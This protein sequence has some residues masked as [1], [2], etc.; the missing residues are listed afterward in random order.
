[1]SRAFKYL[2]TFAAGA[3]ASWWACQNS[4][5]IGKIGICQKSGGCSMGGSSVGGCS[6]G[7]SC[8]CGKGGN[9]QC[10]KGFRG[11]PEKPCRAICLLKPDGG[12]NVNGKVE[13]T[14]DGKV[15]AI[16]AEI[17]GLPPNTK[18]GFHIHQFGDLSEGCKTAGAHYN[19]F[20][21]N[22]GYF[23]YKL[24]ILLGIQE[25]EKR[26]ETRGGGKKKGEEIKNRG[27]N[28][29]ERHVGD[30]GNVVAGKDGK[31]TLDIQDS[32]VK[33]CL[34]LTKYPFFVCFYLK[35]KEVDELLLF[36]RFFKVDHIP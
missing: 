36:V 23:H 6:V 10:G 15:T 18:H 24:F 25:R 5:Q 19:P 14:C 26:I 17:S 3:G 13:L 33:L 20:E 34:V 12:S 30:L 28:D 8:K 27:P 31:A 4:C 35:C 29:E 2:V 1:M 7:G 21:K 9:C 32:Q 11:T 16:H 22:H